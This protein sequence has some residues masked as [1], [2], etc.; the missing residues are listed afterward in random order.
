M[1]EP[2]NQ[3]TQQQTPTEPATQP[4]QQTQQQT[5]EIDYDKIQQMLNGTLA[6]KEET[7]L[8][9][10]FKQQ[11]L[12]QQEAEQAMAAFKAQQK[13]S[14]PDVAQ[15]QADIQT[16]HQNAL[17]A[18]I[19]NKALLLHAEMGIELQTIPYILKLADLSSVVSDGKIDDEKLKASINAVLEAVPQFK[20]QQEQQVQG[21]RQIGAAQQQTAQGVTSQTKEVVA[22]KRWNRFNP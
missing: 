6:A 21:F 12:T 11:G 18:Q 20:Q 14:Q 8:K 13:S 17:K 7:A 19:E 22:T 16:A 9:A 3:T 2:N 15:L 1:A 10:Y 4:Q 5:P